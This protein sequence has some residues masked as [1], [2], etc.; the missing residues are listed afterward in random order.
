MANFADF[1]EHPEI[2]L[3]LEY[4]PGAENPF[5]LLPA[6]IRNIAVLEDTSLDLIGSDTL[7]ALAFQSFGINDFVAFGPND[8]LIFK[9]E[10]QYFSS[11]I[12]PAITCTRRFRSVN[13]C[14]DTPETVEIHQASCLAISSRMAL[15]A[16]RIL[17]TVKISSSSVAKDLLTQ[18]S[19]PC[20]ITKCQSLPMT[21]T[22]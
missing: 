19:C 17:T 21:P 6:Q 4:D 15:R 5:F 11:L 14:F 9:T 12:I 2:D 18:Y 20:K 1:S 7:D 10:S 13:A 22:P 8:T 3:S 16:L